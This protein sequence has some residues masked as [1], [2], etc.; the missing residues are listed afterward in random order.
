MRRGAQ[1]ADHLG[2]KRR[3][4]GVVG[5]VVCVL[6]KTVSDMVCC[7]HANPLLRALT[8]YIVRKPAIPCLGGAAH[9]HISGLT[10][11][12][13]DPRSHQRVNVRIRGPTCGLEGPRARGYARSEQFRMQFD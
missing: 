10:C 1:S 13:A 8:G 5:E 12:L 11:A 4:W 9:A 6:G 7:S 3:Q 2:E